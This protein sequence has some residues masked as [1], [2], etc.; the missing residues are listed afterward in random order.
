MRQR[1]LLDLRSHHF[2]RIV[3]LDILDRTGSIHAAVSPLYF[4][5]DYS[6]R[7]LVAP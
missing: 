3:I 2:A 1:S 7:Y 6:A 5:R 4:L